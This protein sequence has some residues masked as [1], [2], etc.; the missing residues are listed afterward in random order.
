LGYAVLHVV[1]TVGL[2]ALMVRHA[3]PIPARAGARVDYFHHV[4]ADIG[5]MQSVSSDLSTFSGHLLCCNA[6]LDRVHGSVVPGGSLVLLDE[7]GTGTDPA[8]GSALAQA[9]LE[10]VLDAGARVVATTHH[11]RIKEMALT[12]QR[13]QIAAMEFQQGRPTYTL[14]TGSVGESFALAVARGLGLPEGVLHRAHSLLDDTSHRTAELHARLEERVGQASLKQRE[15]EQKISS[16]AATEVEVEALKAEAQELLAGLHEKGDMQYLM[17]LRAKEK[18]LEDILAQ[19][20]ALL[21]AE[22]KQRSGRSGFVTALQGSDVVISLQHKIDGVKAA[23]VEVERT[24]AFRIAVSQ[25]RAT[26]LQPGQAVEEGAELVV[27]EPGGVL[28]GARGVVTHRNRGRGRVVL[29]V[30]GV[31]VKMDRHLLGVPLTDIAA[32][33][34]KLLQMASGE[35]LL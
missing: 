19:A 11:Q 29:R 27:L 23:R 3:V 17:T 18:E 35:V 28:Q 7:L 14:R 12:D 13:C 2:L 20:Q 10:S 33:S 6:M 32:S 24:A 15:F 1:Q 34:K 31:E 4:L 16:V 9:V 21:E 25:L 5:D 30:A 26:P 22:H 8:Q